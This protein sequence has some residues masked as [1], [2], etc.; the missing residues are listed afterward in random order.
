MFMKRVLAFY[1]ESNKTQSTDL[2]NFGDHDRVL[3][4]T[5]LE[6]YILEVFLSNNAVAALK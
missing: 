1:S 2:E 6:K 4:V 5:D 3:N